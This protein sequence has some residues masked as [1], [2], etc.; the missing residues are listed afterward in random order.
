MMINYLAII[1]KDESCCYGLH[2]PDLLGCI[3]VGETLSEVLQK[4]EEALESYLVNETHLPHPSSIRE[5]LMDISE[6]IA[7]GALLI[8]LPYQETATQKK[9]PKESLETCKA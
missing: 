2:F 7:A 6:D 3:A 4:G 9:T 1:Y 8:W 5:L